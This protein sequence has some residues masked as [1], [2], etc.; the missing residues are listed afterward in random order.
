MATMVVGHYPINGDTAEHAFAK[1]KIGE[2][3]YLSLIHI[4][5]KRRPT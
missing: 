3:E 2:T 5:L 1:M 4:F